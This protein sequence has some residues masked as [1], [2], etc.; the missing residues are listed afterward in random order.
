MQPEKDTLYGIHGANMESSSGL[1]HS[2]VVAVVEEI[3][4]LDVRFK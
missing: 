1:S 4:D 2:D 3:H